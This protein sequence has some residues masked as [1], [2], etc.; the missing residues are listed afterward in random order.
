[1]GS[2]GRVLVVEDEE[3]IAQFV[4]DVLRDEGYEVRRALHGRDALDV[5]EDWTP[6]L[7]VLDLMM[8]V[9]DGRAFRTAQR[10]LEGG[11]DRIPVV[12][13]SGAREARAIADE[14]DVAATLTKPFDIEDLLATIARLLQRA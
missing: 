6:D 8:P 14:L 12:V 7:I 1:M 5:L 13:L 11:W 2:A 3:S 4:T 10:A 9:M